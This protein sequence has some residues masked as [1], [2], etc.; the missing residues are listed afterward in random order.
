MFAPERYRAKAAEYTARA[1]ATDAPE[2]AREFEKRERTL[3]TL[4]DNE[5]WL[6]DNHDKTVHGPK[7][8]G[9]TL[10][11]EER[12]AADEERILRCLGAALIMRWNTLPRT[13]QRELFDDAGAMG[14]VANAT[15]LRGQI[16]RFLHKHKDDED[17][18]AGDAS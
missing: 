5:Q 10:A 3:T 15:M 8:D 13:L 7:P 17:G 2:K 16:A 6:A 4:A 12:L 14:E 9:T 1:K 18:V 11:A